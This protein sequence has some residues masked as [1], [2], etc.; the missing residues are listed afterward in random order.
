[1]CLKLVVQS[2]GPAQ[3]VTA[4][5]V[6]RTYEGGS[7]VTNVMPYGYCHCG[8]GQKT[9]IAIKTKNGVKRGEPLRYLRGHNSNANPLNRDLTLVPCA[10]CGKP[11]FP[12]W[13]SGYP[14]KYCDREC[15]RAAHRGT[16]TKA[17]Q[18]R[19]SKLLHFYGI[20]NGGYEEILE[21]QGGGCAICGRTTHGK[22]LKRLY[23]DHDHKTQA[24]RGVLCASCNRAIG[25]MQDDSE[26]L[27]KA[28]DY[29]DR[30]NERWAV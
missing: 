13:R 23:V 26:R 27:R 16:R 22:G 18:E 30:A 10:H 29:L 21:S 28:A 1:M 25:L 7:D 3:L 19:D 20:D 4:G 17:E 14:R 11:I 9:N 12:V 6:A 8:C 24:V 5:T 15:W 2:S